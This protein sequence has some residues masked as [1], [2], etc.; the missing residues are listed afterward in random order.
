MPFGVQLLVR[1]AATVLLIGLGAIG[2]GW[3]WR[4]RA[5]G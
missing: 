4:R 2:L 3:G 5:R 1:D